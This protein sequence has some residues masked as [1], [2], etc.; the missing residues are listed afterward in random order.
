MPPLQHG[1][2]GCL[3]F[4]KSGG[5]SCRCCLAEALLIG[6]ERVDYWE[7]AMVDGFEGVVGFYPG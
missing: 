1:S 4:R 2:R 5:G 3:G 7:E 6:D